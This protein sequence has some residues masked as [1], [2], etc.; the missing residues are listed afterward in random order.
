MNREPDMS[1]YLED[2]R[3]IYITESERF[4]ADIELILRLVE[5]RINILNF[6]KHNSF[7]DILKF[8]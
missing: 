2:R 4:N 8:N 3:Q 1:Q 5:F 7:Y 6:H